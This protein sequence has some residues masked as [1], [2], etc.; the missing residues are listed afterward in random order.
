MKPKQDLVP[1]SRNEESPK[2]QVRPVQASF[3]PVNARIPSRI[4]TVG[5]KQKGRL[6]APHL[7][8]HFPV[9]IQHH[10]DVSCPRLSGLPTLEFGLAS[11]FWGQNHR[12]TWIEAWPGQ[13]LLRHGIRRQDGDRNQG[14]PGDRSATGNNPKRRRNIQ[15]TTGLGS[16]PSNPVT[17][18]PDHCVFYRHQGQPPRL[19]AIPER[20]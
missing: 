13:K 4:P 2:S 5:E 16:L 20:P 14:S 18:N 12:F 8:A 3:L 9:G 17:R 1:P 7:D 10:P 6:A 15:L 11:W 19:P